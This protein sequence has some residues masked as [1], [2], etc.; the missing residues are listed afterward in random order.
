MQKKVVKPVSL[1]SF[2]PRT[3][4]TRLRVGSRTW[5]GSFNSSTCVQLILL[6]I[7]TLTTLLQ[8]QLTVDTHMA[9]ADTQTMVVDIHRKVLTMQ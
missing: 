2:S 7:L 6:E 5:L 9:V 4:S 3:I 1:D 8:I